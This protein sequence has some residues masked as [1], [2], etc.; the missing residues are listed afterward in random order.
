MAQ[1]DFYAANKIAFNG[2]FKGSETT[3]KVN[4]VLSWKSKENSTLFSTVDDAQ[5]DSKAFG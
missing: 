2:K 5:V 3:V 1:D 4:S